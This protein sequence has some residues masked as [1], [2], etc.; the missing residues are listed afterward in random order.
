MI[1][2]TGASSGI[3]EATARAFAKA[4]ARL[5]LVSEQEEQLP[6]VAQSLCEA[7]GQAAA[8][9][10]DFSKPEQVEGLVARAE[11]VMGPLEV[12]VNNAGVGLGASVLDTKPS[13]LRFLFE[14]NFFA[15][16]NLCRQALAVMAPRGQGRIINVSSAAGRLGG[17]TIG[18]YAATKG[19]V[20]AYT[21]ALR[22][23]ARAYGVHV[24]EV[25]P[26][27]VR[28]RF[29]QNVKGEKYRPSGIVLTSEQVAD[30]IVRCASA[31][32]PKAEVLPYRPIRAV[33]VL[34]ALFPG[35]LDRF[36]AKEFAESVRRPPTPCPS[37]QEQGEGRE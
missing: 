28:T 31:R 14:V 23:E 10:A 6:A 12:L 1:L 16:A 25:L 37:P 36:A 21:N 26:I 9:V 19:A 3:G 13:D 22:M 27:S 34:D 20:H 32:H 24:S 18:A 15:L 30:S 7:G 17:T 33:F 29:F 4:G 5:V 8:I 11:Q 35:L 2:I